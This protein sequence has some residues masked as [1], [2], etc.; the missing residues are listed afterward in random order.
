MKILLVDDD[1]FLRALTCKALEKAGYEVTVAVDGGEAVK[2]ATEDNFD[3]LI[4][5]IFMPV[6]EGL[7]VIQE[8]RAMHPAIKI[9][10]I[11]LDGPTGFS[12]FLKMAIV[13]GAQ[14]CLEKPFSP[15][16]LLAKVA[17]VTAT[18]AR[19]SS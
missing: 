13:F 5:D 15:E 2:K 4:T 7:E 11:S 12:T 6:K 9:I 14:G 18:A 17:E 10:A 3:L 19:L 1:A 8:I 16:Q